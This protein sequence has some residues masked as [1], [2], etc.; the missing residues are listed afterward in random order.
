MAARRRNR[1]RV[2]NEKD[3]GKGKGNAKQRRNAALTEKGRSPLNVTSEAEETKAGIINK[4]ATHGGSTRATCPWLLLL[5]EFSAQV[6]ALVWDE[7]LGCAEARLEAA[8][9]AV[10]KQSTT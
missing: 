5:H 9:A 2:S 8:H 1:S 7:L 3:D 10:F 6:L 4:L